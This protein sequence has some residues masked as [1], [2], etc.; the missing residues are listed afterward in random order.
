MK[1]LFYNAIL[2]LFMFIAF[3]GTAQDQ[4]LYS[5][6]LKQTDQFLTYNQGTLVMA[7]THTGTNKIAQCFIVKRLDNGKTL[8]G[9]AAKPG[10]FL[11]RE[12]SNIVLVPYSVGDTSFEWYLNYSGYP[13][14]SLMQ[15]GTDNALGWQ[16][17]G[18]NML[19][20]SPGL[21]TNNDAAG[22]TYRFEISTVTT[23]F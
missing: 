13:Y 3:Y 5:F 23:T 20:V 11:K 18:F 6:S 9:A 8:I 4:K 16:G 22:D 14:T 15:P 1:T 7:D 2:L 21:S 17:G 10:L 12:A 19:S